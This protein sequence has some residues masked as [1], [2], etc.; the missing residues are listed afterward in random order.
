MRFRMVI[1]I[2]VDSKLVAEQRLVK[3]EDLK[4]QRHKQPVLPRYV[5]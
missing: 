4:G 5:R 2:R 1:E 3:A